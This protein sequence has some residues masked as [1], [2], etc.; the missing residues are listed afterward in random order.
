VRRIPEW[1]T[2]NIEKSKKAVKKQIQQK[3]KETIANVFQGGNSKKPK[4]PMQHVQDRK[5][6]PQKRSAEKTHTPNPIPQ[7]IPP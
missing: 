7:Q 3:K 5:R 1:W 2:Q 4:L 6:M